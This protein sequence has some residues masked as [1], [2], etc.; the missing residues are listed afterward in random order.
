MTGGNVEKHSLAE[1]LLTR[2][3]PS[4][5]GITGVGAPES[6]SSCGLDYFH[7][8]CLVFIYEV[9]PPFPLQVGGSYTNAPKPFQTPR[10]SLVFE[11]HRH[12]MLCRIC[13]SKRT[14]LETHATNVKYSLENKY[15]RR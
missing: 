4:Y 1:S 2:F 13:I 7:L 15:L 8:K 11:N 12:A 10:K 5:D 9:S 14:R 6:G 3:L